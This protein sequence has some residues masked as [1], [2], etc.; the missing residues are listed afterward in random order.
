MADGAEALIPMHERKESKV[1]EL[2]E[3]QQIVDEVHVALTKYIASW[4]QANREGVNFPSKL[5]LNHWR[6]VLIKTLAI[7]FKKLLQEEHEKEKLKEANDTQ[8]QALRELISM[9]NRMAF[10]LISFLNLVSLCQESTSFVIPAQDA[11]LTQDQKKSNDTLVARLDAIEKFLLDSNP[12]TSGSQNLIPP[13]ELL[14]ATPGKNVPYDREVILEMYFVLKRRHHNIKLTKKQ[15]ERDGLGAQQILNLM[16]KLNFVSPI[17]PP[18][19]HSQTYSSKTMKRTASEDRLIDFIA[20]Q[21]SRTMANQRYVMSE[22]KERKMDLNEMFKA[23]DKLGNR[24]EDQTAMT[25]KQREA[26]NFAKVEEAIDRANRSTMTDQRFTL[27]PE[28]IKQLSLTDLVN[29]VER[30]AHQRMAN[31]DAVSPAERKREMLN[32][33]ADVVEKMRHSSMDD[34][35]FVEKVANRMQITVKELNQSIDSLP[36]DSSSLHSQTQL[37]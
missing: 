29:T 12:K 11:S 15:K 21:N 18:D 10:E 37:I 2:R 17:W 5:A 1:K 26:E 33:V 13:E 4:I 30:L 36:S 23:V 20:S 9:D 25:R 24:F 35:R 6:E 27:S 31:Q 8:L 34:Q 32:V 22:Q 3:D 14:I 19:P 7:V 28:K 16:T